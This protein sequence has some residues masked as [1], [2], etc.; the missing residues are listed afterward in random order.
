MNRR[1]FVLHTVSYL[2]LVLAYMAAQ[3]AFSW[4]AP[5]VFGGR[6]AMNLL[7]MVF[8]SSG[9]ALFGFFHGRVSSRRGLFALLGL[10]GTARAAMVLLPPGALAAAA[11]VVFL[12]T[13]GW[14]LG[15]VFFLTARRVPRDFF[16]RFVGGSMA[17]ATG[18][19][20]LLSLLR[21]FPAL[22]PGAAS[23]FSASAFGVLAWL[24]CRGASAPEPP[25]V[26]VPCLHVLGRAERL[27]LILGVAFLLSFAYGINDSIS[28][29]RFAD[30]QDSFG[31]SRLAL[32]A[33][34]FAAGALA[35]RKR[36]YLPLAALLSASATMA[37]H[38]MALEGLPVIFLFCANEFFWAFSFLF[39][40][41]VFMEASL[42]TERPELWAGMGRL[43]EMPAEG[44]GAA[45]G[46]AMI[47][48]LPPSA[49]LTAYTLTLA[50]AAGLLH[51]S[52]LSRAERTTPK[53][54]TPSV[55][56]AAP[57]PMAA[58]GDGEEAAETTTAPLSPQ[59]ALL[60]NWRERYGL[61][62]RETEV[63][64]VSLAGGKAPDIAKA[65][66]ISTATVRFHLTNL[67][68]KTG[69]TSRT[70]LKAAFARGLDEEC[71]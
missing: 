56:G 53:G 36:D 24:L 23:M 60:E 5:F 61:T 22:Y 69:F 49:V 51:H 3:S 68:K 26:A 11:A 70:E 28:Y 18:L 14:L 19:M 25:I 39:I 8:A 43:V 12:L 16:G 48:A 29:L 2:H 6:T 40:L 47:T 31:L 52:F 30:L 50:A 21:G 32:C 1:L 67:L 10:N 42:R 58:V 44:I 41:L 9:M 38:A 37:F 63:L 64:R 62:S 65:L 66:F 13:C 45:A 15:L 17:L 59:E 20:F 46:G 34:F 54:R 55:F 33:G 27:P 71:E 57:V 4:L 7:Y 35:D